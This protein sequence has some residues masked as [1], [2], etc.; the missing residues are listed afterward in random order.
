MCEVYHSLFDKLQSFKEQSKFIMHLPANRFPFGF[1]K[2]VPILSE[3]G[4]SLTC[5]VHSAVDRKLHH[6]IDQ[7]ISIHLFICLARFY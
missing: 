3:P 6:G 2:V 5:K 4:S 7:Y 1:A